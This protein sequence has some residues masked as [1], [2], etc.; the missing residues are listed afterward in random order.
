MSTA[1]KVL[2][3]LVM[4]ASIV[5]LILAGGIAQLNYNANQRLQKLSDDLAKAQADIETTRHEMAETRDRTTETQENIDRDLAALG[6]QQADLDRTRSQIVD[7]LERLKYDLGT[8]NATIAGAR[9]SLENRNAEFDAE[10][11]ATDELRRGVQSLKT[12]NAQLMARLGS[13]RDQFQKNYHAN[14]EMLGK[15]R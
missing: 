2:A 3:V 13:L 7:T 6:S 14:V 5:C 12:N 9:T 1:G 4:L 15:G 10:Q 11:K 8:V